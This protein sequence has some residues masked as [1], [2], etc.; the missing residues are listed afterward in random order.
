M[1]IQAVHVII[2][3]GDKKKTERVEPG[4]KFDC[5]DDE[6]KGYVKSGAATAVAAE[7]AESKAEK[8]AAKKPAAKK[9]AADKAEPAG[10]AAAAA[11]TDNDPL[12]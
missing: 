5:P 10:A 2:R 12:S 6:A 8:P 9:P 4:T 1:Q 3:K 7:K 11:S